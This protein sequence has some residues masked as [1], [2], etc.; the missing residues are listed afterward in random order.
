MKIPLRL[1]ALVLCVLST[2]PRLIAREPVPAEVVVK[3][4]NSVDFPVH[5]T[6]L[7]NDNGDRSTM[8]VLDPS[9]RDPQRF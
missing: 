4:A 8:P 6:L 7:A 5:R 2:I 1:A 9:P 3:Y